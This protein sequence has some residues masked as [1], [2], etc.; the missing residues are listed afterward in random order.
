M[1]Y[2][3]KVSFYFT[4]VNNEQINV[5][6]YMSVDLPRHHKGNVKEV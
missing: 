5:C 2:N 6:T 4:E 1:A 3:F